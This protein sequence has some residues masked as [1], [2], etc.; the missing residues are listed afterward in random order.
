MPFKP[1]KSKNGGTGWLAAKPE[2]LN[3]S[4]LIGTKWGLGWYMWRQRRYYLI[5]LCLFF[6]VFSAFLEKERASGK[7]SESVY[8]MH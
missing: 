8:E 1:N 3:E 4:R 2:T 6:G 7:I 5:P